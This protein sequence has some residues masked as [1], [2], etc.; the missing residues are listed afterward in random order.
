MG[1]RGELAILAG[2]LMRDTD[3]D[4]PKNVKRLAEEID[5]NGEYGKPG[6]GMI[7][8]LMDDVGQIYPV[9]KAGLGQ[10][11]WYMQHEY[12]EAEVLL[13][14]D[15]TERLRFLSKEQKDEVH[16]RLV[17][18]TFPNARE[19]VQK[20]ARCT[21]PG[22]REIPADYRMVIEK[23]IQTRKRI[24]FYYLAFD[25]WKRPV[26]K[27]DGKLYIVSPYQCF[28][29]KE[30][31]YVI[32]SEEAA[33]KVKKFRVDRM[34]G[35][36]LSPER[37]E[38]VKKYF[39]DNPEEQFWKMRDRSVD[40]FYGEE[41]FLELSV[42]F[43]TKAMDILD[44]LAGDAC[45]V[46]GY[47]RETNRTHVGFP[48]GRSVTLTGWLLQNTEFFTVISPQCVIED[49]LAVGKTVLFRYGPGQSMDA[50]P[51]KTERDPNLYCKSGG[52][53][54][55]NNTTCFDRIIE[56]I[57]SNPEITVA[58]MAASLGIPKRTLERRIRH[59]RAVGRIWHAGSPRSGHWEVLK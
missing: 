7:Y 18:E 6:R 15:V 36:F 40:Y 2:R 44:D 45:V 23:G 19:L 1:K 8:R 24:C 13:V 53:S 12:N 55:G 54:G 17:A 39:P 30:T 3:E 26:R 41:I 32:G 58:E 10:S 21:S 47:D 33:G 48:I 46:F 25:E 38:P 49:L 35:L 42:A 28:F 29:G 14:S 50:E 5:P 20:M 11:G 37:S 52:N 9:H 51:C 22:K 59:L 27:H 43:S 31:L 16:R 34:D 4:H 56:L 57:S